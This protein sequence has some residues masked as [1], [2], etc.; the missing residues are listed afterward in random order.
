MKLLRQEINKLFSVGTTTALVFIAFAVGIV[1]TVF[2]GVPV[3]AEPER[4]GDVVEVT[5][6]YTDTVYLAWVFPPLMGVLFMTGEFRM[7]T[8]VHT[9]LQTPRRGA[10]VAAKM[11]A[12]V[13]GGAI[14]A[15]ASLAGAFLT[16]TVI[17]QIAGDPV[18]PDM[19]R[20]L[21]ATVG[22]VGTGAMVAPM[23]VA[24]GTLVRSQLAALGIFLGWV[25]LIEQVFVG[26]LG[27]AGVFMPGA[28]MT[29]AVS[30]DFGTATL[31]D[32]Y[33]GLTPLVAIVL[34]G[35][36]AIVLAMIGSVTTLRRDID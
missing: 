2:A 22:L 24:V 7:G 28:L 10:V 4:A 27:P 9:F 15:L 33:G 23:G 16:A 21:G 29:R 17:T 19:D 8:A 34:L 32:L 20:L 30:L 36:E 1:L 31:T 5:N 13:V 25:L 11:A 26:L 3:L 18:M 35:V 12:S 6:L 14:V